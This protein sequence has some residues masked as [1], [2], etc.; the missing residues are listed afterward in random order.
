MSKHR[1]LGFAVALAA[2]GIVS[3]TAVWGWVFPRISGNASPDGIE[4]AYSALESLFAGLTLLGLLSTIWMQR[5][6]LRLQREELAQTRLELRR[7]AE[8]QEKSERALNAQAAALHEEAERQSRAYLRISLVPSGNSSWTLEIANVGR[9]AAEDVQLH[10]DRQVWLWASEDEL[11]L[12]SELPLFAKGGFSIPAG[13]TLSYALQDSRVLSHVFERR[14][15]Q[16]NQF[17]IQ[18]QYRTTSGR[19]VDETSRFSLE[20]L[21]ETASGDRDFWTRQLVQAVR[22]LRPRDP[23]S[24]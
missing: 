15:E 2:M 3:L 17:S 4:A 16:P 1:Q 24:R 14:I 20:L 18:A 9:T 10:V 12:L 5:A 8:A 23:A 19:S 7:Q 11:K 22:D 13:F 21:Q 6:E